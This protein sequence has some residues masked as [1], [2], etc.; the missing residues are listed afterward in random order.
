MKKFTLF[1]AALFVAFSANAA[2]TINNPVGADGR[3]IV[4]YDLQNNRFFDSN[5]MEVDETFVFAVD[6]TGSWLEDWLKETPTVEGASRGVAFNNWTNY[7]DTNG[8]V[9]RLKQISGNIYGFTVNFYQVMVNEELKPKALMEDSV[10]YVYGQLFG[11]EYTNDNPGANWWMW[12]N[13]EVD[14]TLAPESDC[15][16]AFEPYSGAKHCADLFADDYENGDI[17]GFTITGYAAP[18]PQPY[19][20]YVTDNTEWEATTLYVWDGGENAQQ[21]GTWP[22]SMP[23]G[24][25]KDGTKVWNL[26]ATE[27]TYNLIFNNN[28]GGTQL[29]DFVAEA[30]KDYHLVINAEGVTEEGIADAI[31]NINS[32]AEVVAVEY[33]SILGTKMAQAPEQGVYIRSEILSNG[34]R[35]SEKVFRF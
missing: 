25:K 23:N 14:A 16:F 33:F 3:Y 29:A 27:G 5:S 2:Y 13:N 12:G 35:K 19:W 26:K 11:F 10:V 9:R 18:V 20:I 30:N 22:G 15:L 17:F 8:D 6:V 32:Q 34:Q 24:V 28:G 21:L 1:V 7:G 31:D 4:K